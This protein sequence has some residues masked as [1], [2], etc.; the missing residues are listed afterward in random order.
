MP[1]AQTKLLKPGDWV[2]WYS[3]IDA[4]VDG[5]VTSVTPAGVKRRH[6]NIRIEWEDG[7]I[8]NLRP[9]QLER[10]TFERLQS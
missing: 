3:H 4:H 10:H 2:R 9:D 8:S 6:P 5:K 1:P 7:H